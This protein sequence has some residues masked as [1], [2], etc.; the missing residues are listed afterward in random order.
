M[1]QAYKNFYT[2]FST[3]VMS[4]AGTCF[5]VVQAA[6]DAEL[7]IEV[8][9]EVHP[10]Y[11]RYQSETEAATAE[12]IFREAAD[13]A[14]AD[15]AVNN[16][17][18]Y[19]AVSE[20]LATIRCEHTEAELPVALAEW[21]DSTPTMLPV[22]FKWVEDTAIITGVAAGTLGVA[23]GDELLAVDGHSMS[24]LLDEMATHISVDGFTDHTK[25]ALFAGRDDVGLTT[26]DMFYPLLHGFSDSFMLSLR[27][28]GG[29][30][31]EARVAAV[32]ES[33][34]LA[35]RGLSVDWANFSDPDAVVWQQVGD[36]AVLTISTFVNYRTP[37]VPDEVFGAVLR[38]I[39]ASDATRLVL[40]LRNVGGGSSDVMES[41][42]AHLI[43]QPMTIGGATRVKTYEFAKFREHLSTW[44]ESVFTLPASRFTPDG[45]GLYF[46]NPENGS[47]TKVLQPA[48]DAWHG[49]LTA[50][51]GAGNE[52]ALTMLLAELRD[53][54]EV[55]LIGQPTGGSAQGPTAGVLATLT[56]PE[57]QI[58]VRVPLRW[59]LTSFKD[60][61]FGQGITPDILVPETIADL[62]AGRDRTLE[63]ATTELGR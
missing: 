24:G 22:S 41:L 17:A 34:A 16:G 46:L 19:L 54:R 5:N 47:D 18:F 15:G 25:A 58:L 14:T 44:N 40:D 35:A 49:P 55:T 1:T 57:S 11:L 36:A 56:L 28:E 43:G 6:P 27:T 59:S 10:G 53:E 42:L 63:I 32:D 9:R 2:V 33:T 51:I 62:R 31:H 39:K 7:L 52:S 20:Y 12:R 38:E 8:M 23:I 37:V 26:F 3:L 21:R 13:R 60:F 61:E 4:V 45:A 30:R 50:L 29:E 48:A